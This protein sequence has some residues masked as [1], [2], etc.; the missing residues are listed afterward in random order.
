MVS[1]RTSPHKIKIERTINGYLDADPPCLGVS[2]RE[3]CIEE[4]NK[5]VEDNLTR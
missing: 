5:A 2:V 4:S 1:G 3:E